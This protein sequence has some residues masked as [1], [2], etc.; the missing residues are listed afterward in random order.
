M[1]SNTYHPC[2]YNSCHTDLDD[3]TGFSPLVID[4]NDA[5]DYM[6]YTTCPRLFSPGQSQRM[7]NFL[8]GTRHLLLVSNGCGQNGNVCPPIAGFSYS[9]DTCQSGTVTLTDT[10]QNYSMLYYW[11]FDNNGTYDATGHTVTHQF[12]T[13]G[14][15]TVKEKVI[16]V[17]GI[18]STYR[19]ITVQYAGWLFYPISSF[20]GGTT[21]N[22]GNIYACAG[23]P[24]SFYS[25]PAL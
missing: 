2:P 13:T 24:L 25:I 21:D 1:Q 5:P 18:D 15:H 16:G 12:T 6:D 19:T 22:Q 3:T 11:D 9:A 17:G 7:N 14:T 10:S 8:T 23:T 20:S 4:V